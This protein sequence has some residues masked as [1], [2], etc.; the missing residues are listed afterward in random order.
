MLVFLNDRVNNF[1][2]NQNFTMS[3]AL[4]ETRPAKS[5]EDSNI[6]INEADAR[7][8]HNTDAAYV[9]PNE[10]V[11]LVSYLGFEHNHTLVSRTDSVNRTSNIEHQ[12]LELQSRLLYRLMGNKVFH[13]PLDRSEIHK[14][15]DIGCGTGAVTHE[16]ASMFPDAQVLGA[17]LSPVPGIRQ[18]LPNISYVQGNIMELEDVRFERNSFDLIFSRLLVLGMPNWKAYVERCVALAKPGVS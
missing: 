6:A 16:M 1:S 7:T 15:L 14:T 5:S 18:K 3:T 12:R 10:Y 17:D 9:L 13:S 11:Q 2:Q 8:F 4:T